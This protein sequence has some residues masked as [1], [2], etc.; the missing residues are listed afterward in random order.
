MSPATLGPSPF[1]A[2]S[3]DVGS[4][5]ELRFALDLKSSESWQFLPD[6]PL[7]PRQLPLQATMCS[8]PRWH[9]SRGGEPFKGSGA[10]AKDEAKAEPSEQQRHHHQHQ[11]PLPCRC[12]GRSQ[13]WACTTETPWKG[14]MEAGGG[15]RQIWSNRA[16]CPAPFKSHLQKTRGVRR[17]PLSYI[18]ASAGHVSHF[19][20]AWHEFSWPNAFLP[21]LPDEWVPE[22]ALRARRRVPISNLPQ[23]SR[24]RVEEQI[25]GTRCRAR[26]RKQALRT[27]P[28]PLTWMFSRIKSPFL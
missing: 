24:Q 2:L 20:F 9:S 25:F 11:G 21:R 10:A 19:I 18:M 15:K 16:G 7:P 27:G 17:H 13:R 1:F 23:A 8:K 12:H 6:L 28:A 5:L 26:R 3:L 22:C 4:A 14:G